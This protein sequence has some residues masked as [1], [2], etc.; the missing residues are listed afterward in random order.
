VVA[1]LTC[2]IVLFSFS[3]GLILVYLARTLWRGRARQTRCEADGGS[4]LVSKALMEMGYWLFDPVADALAALS[5]TPNMVTGFS[6]VPA[7]AAGVAAAF[8]RF[9]LAYVLATSASLCD[10]VDGVLARKLGTASEAGELVDAAADRYV[11]SFFLCGLIVYY[12]AHWVVLLLGLGA[13]LGTFMMSQSTAQ[14]EAIGVQPPRGLMRRAERAIYLLTGSGLTSVSRVIFASSASF[15]A[16]EF[17]I[18]AALTAVAVIAN[19]SA[20]QRFAAIA[21]ALRARER[22]HAAPGDARS[23]VNLTG[24]APSSEARGSA[25]AI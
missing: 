6:L 8:G 12:R 23:G 5:V 10:L 22:K 7:L 1:D 11:E 20:A 24:P 14:A 16:R 17:P 13:L 25:T 3:A 9:G 19:I 15:A 4:V 2:A 21:R 18:I